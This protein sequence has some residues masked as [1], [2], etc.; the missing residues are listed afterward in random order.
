VLRHREGG[1]FSESHQFGFSDQP[2]LIAFADQKVLLRVGLAFVGGGVGG[3]VG[4]GLRHGLELNQVQS[5]TGLS[6]M[7]SRTERQAG[8]VEINGNGL[9]AGDGGAFRQCAESS[10][11]SCHG[12]G[13]EEG[14]NAEKAH[15]TDSSE[16]C[17]AT[18]TGRSHPGVRITLPSR[19]RQGVGTPEPH[20]PKRATVLAFATCPHRSLTLAAQQI[21]SS[22][23][24]PCRTTAGEGARP[25]IL[26]SHKTA[27]PLL[28]TQ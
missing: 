16:S 24:R 1:E 27:S 23:P 14:A 28:A 7:E 12:S 8:A 13:K 25:T 4:E 17:H 21:A 20:M 5:E 22:A 15:R 18:A 19:D 26:F 11:R 3:D 6:V 2:P 10:G 9:K